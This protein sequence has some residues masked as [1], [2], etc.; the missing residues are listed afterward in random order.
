MLARANLAAG[1]TTWLNGSPARSPSGRC[2]RSWCP[3]LPWLP[4]SAAPGRSSRSSSSATAGGSH[5][6]IARAVPNAYFEKTL[7]LLH[8]MHQ[9]GRAYFAGLVKLAALDTIALGIR[10]WL[11]GLWRMAARPD[12]GGARLGALRW[13]DRRVPAGRYPWR[14]PTSRTTG[15]RLLRDRALLAGAAAG[16]LRVPAGDREAEPPRIRW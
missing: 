16:R 9:T 13:L 10:L 1:V 5:R 2:S 14:R 6:F 11:L 4:G 8:E 3:W 15:R 12:R 7:D